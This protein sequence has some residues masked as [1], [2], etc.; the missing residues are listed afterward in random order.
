VIFVAGLSG[1]GKTRAAESSGIPSLTLDSFY[2][3]ATPSIPRWLGRPDWETLR[4]YDLREA[5]SAVR[6]LARGEPVE[7]P[8]YDHYASQVIG[9]VAATPAPVFVAEGVYA[10][11]VYS[12]VS[13]EGIEAA[14]LAIDVPA[15]KALLARLR[16]DI[17]ARHM[18]LL[19]A[20]VRSSRLYARHSH[21]R[22]EALK[23]GAEFVSRESAP[24]RIREL[25]RS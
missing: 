19:W 14:L 24:L 1:S 22:R 3:D 23:Q 4:S 20:L 11:L 15:R 18:N 8:T 16:R 5:I 9:S 10:P 17:R 12:A 21:Y 25:A 7:I 13:R 6:S 2:L